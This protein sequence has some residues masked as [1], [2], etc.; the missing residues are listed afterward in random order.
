ME[1]LKK[2]QK[3]TG[4]QVDE[5]VDARFD[6]KMDSTF[7]A[8]VRN[9]FVDNLSSLSFKKNGSRKHKKKLDPNPVTKNTSLVI[10]NK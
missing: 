5:R 6:S 9:S 2:M 8:R 7:P 1:K 3:A 4:V 10:V